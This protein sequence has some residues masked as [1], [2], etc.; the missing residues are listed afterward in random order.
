MTKNH[1]DL[2]QRRAQIDVL[3]DQLLR[4]LNQR[5]QVVCE[6]AS[7]KRS[8]GLPV[9]DGLREQWVV[10]RMC[11]RNQGPLDT[12]GLT[13]IFRCIIRE[14]R[15]IEEMA[16]QGNRENSF[17]QENCNGYQHGSKRNRS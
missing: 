6:V 13:S 4:L 11:E 17:L 1:D 15:K 2:H 16:M 14:S 12:E 9:Y 10:Q 8:S 5:A 3:D 7:I